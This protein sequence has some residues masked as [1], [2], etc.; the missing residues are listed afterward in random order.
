MCASEATAVSVW[1]RVRTTLVTIA[2]KTRQGIK[3]RVALAYQRQWLPP[4]IHGER[5]QVCELDAAAKVSLT[6]ERA[7]GET[8][9]GIA[10][11]GANE[12]V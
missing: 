6:H 10:T 11:S 2:V 5:C 8:K 7:F 12:R 3:A 4:A 1:V 9:S